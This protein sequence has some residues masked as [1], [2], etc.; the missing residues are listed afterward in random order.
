MKQLPSEHANVPGITNECGGKT[1]RRGKRLSGAGELL[2]NLMLFS[3]SEGR[4]GELVSRLSHRD[5]A[6]H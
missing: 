4:E 1:T 2:R 5:G 6:T 3:F